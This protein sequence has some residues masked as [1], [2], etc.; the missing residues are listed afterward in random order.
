MTPKKLVVSLAAG[1]LCLCCSLGGLMH[2]DFLARRNDTSLVHRCWLK[3]YARNRRNSS[4]SSYALL[5]SLLVIMKFRPTKK[6]TLVAWTPSIVL[7]LFFSIR[8]GV[9][10][11]FPNLSC[12]KINPGGKEMMCG[13]S[14]SA[15][16]IQS[17]T[18][19]FYALYF[20]GLL[21]SVFHALRGV[22]TKIGG[23]GFILSLIFVVAGFMLRAHFG[24]EDSP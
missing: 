7:V 5:I 13:F 18:F 3:P 15:P 4:I 14:Y 11:Y 1:S 2:S 6:N 17:I 22:L 9:D 12:S 24:T 23:L 19:V 8:V 10:A 21:L 16:I 20:G